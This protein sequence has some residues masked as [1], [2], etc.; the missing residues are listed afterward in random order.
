MSDLAQLRPRLH[1]V[2]ITGTNGKTTT[3]SM[4][5]AIVAAAGEVSARATTLGTW[6]DDEQLSE[7]VSLDAFREV[8]REAI[9]RGARTLAVETT[10]KSL[11]AGFAR[12]WPADVAVFT[13]LTRD[14]LD[15]HGTPEAYLAAKAQL[16]MTVPPGG[17]VVWNLGDPCSALLDGL[18][19]PEVRRFGWVVGEVH[20]ECAGL[21]LHLS[22]SGVRARVGGT[23]FDVRGS[24]GCEALSGTFETPSVG[25]VH[26]Q[27]ALSA[28]LATAALGYPAEAIWRGVGAFRGVPGRFEIVGQAPVVVVDYAHTPD[29]LERTLAEARAL[30][31]ERAGRVLCVFGCGGE[32]DRGKRP[33]MGRIADAHADV[34]IL[35]SDNPRGEDPGRIL[36]DIESELPAGPRGAHWAREPDRRAA[37]QRAIEGAAPG[38]VVVIAGRGHERK[39]LL[40]GGAVNFSDAQV[41][42][43]ALASAASA[44]GGAPM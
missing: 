14:H 5:A 32:R 1:S 20:P 27:N 36:D 9:R 31:D 13:N 21:P 10:S 18:V 23:R 4:V 33:Q 12:A 41:A 6:V 25:A 30:L 24:S 44:A 35:T 3:T 29:A 38:D 28:A 19:S 22:A 16:F 11:A 43:E 17:A 34:V 39:L 40:A 8:A 7:D 2:G 15:A 26:V 42:R 37:I